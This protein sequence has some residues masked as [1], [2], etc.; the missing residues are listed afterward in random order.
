MFP[1]LAMIPVRENS[2]VVMKFTQI[3]WN[4]CEHLTQQMTHVAR[5][6]STMG[7][8]SMLG[9]DFLLSGDHYKVA[10]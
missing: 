8:R 1:L 2:E 6:T 3:L 9:P 4:I 5:N 7:R 10:R